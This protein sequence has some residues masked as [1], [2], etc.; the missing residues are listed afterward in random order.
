MK[1][2]SFKTNQPRGFNFK[3][4]YYNA[5]HEEFEA[6]KEQSIREFKLEQK[7]GLS[8]EELRDKLRAEWR[9]QHDSKTAA[10][11]STYRVAIIA[12]TLFAAM[13]LYL[14]TDFFA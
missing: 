2:T 12:L 14:Y 5:Q 9:N 7:T 8:T 10:R 1:I 13:Y 4:R 3:A 6:R 11:V